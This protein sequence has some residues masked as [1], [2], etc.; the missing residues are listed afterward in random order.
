MSQCHR[1]KTILSSKKVPMPIDSL[2]SNRD[3]GIEVN[4]RMIFVK[5][6]RLKKKTGRLLSMML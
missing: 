1:K 4:M 2:Y 3:R 5:M 6:E